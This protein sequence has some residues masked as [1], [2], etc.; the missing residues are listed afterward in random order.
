MA[1]DAPEIG[2][3]IEQLGDEQLAR[4]KDAGKRLEEI[5]EPA[6]EQLRK[7]ERKHVDPDVRL[8]AGILVRAI[9]N[10]GWSEERVI[11]G[12]ARGYWLNRVAF[13]PDGKQA[14]AAG[15]GLIL[16][17]LASGRE[18][19]RVLE[20]GG[21]R[22]GLSLSKDG[23]LCLTG[24][25]NDGV[26]QLLELPTCRVV[27]S[28]TE[29][30]PGVQGVALSPDA[31][32]AATCGNDGKLRVWDVKTGKEVFHRDFLDG[33]PNCVAFSSDGKQLL[34]G[35]QARRNEA[36]I[37]L[38]NAESGKEV[39][40]F[41]SHTANVMAVSFLPDGKQFVSGGMDGSI[42]L[43]QTESGKELHQFKQQGGV[44]DL[45]VSPDG[46]RLLSA[47][48]GDKSVRVWDVV[49]R[50]EL[51]RLSAHTEHALGVA[52]SRDGR[53]AISCDADCTLR[54]WSVPP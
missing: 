26:A 31:S 13:L 16:Y 36:Q 54:L 3:L 15:G 27:K 41:R 51:R 8:R 25:T 45:A 32:K 44:Y 43:W 46:R 37:R 24:H 7:A 29:H 52:F 10:K 53:K 9:E 42:R 4:R 18:Q 49:S 23:K 34:S 12:Q 21:A 22:M 39:R 38:W 47:G 50:K 40:T 20:R 33:P 35:H 2:K 48:F 11:Q 28:F 19:R 14:V 17:D 1:V 30:G 5:G 6:L